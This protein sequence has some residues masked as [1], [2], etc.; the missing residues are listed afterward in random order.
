MFYIY[1]L[2]CLFFK[3]FFALLLELASFNLIMYVYSDNKGILFYLYSNQK[4]IFPTTGLSIW[5][6]LVSVAQL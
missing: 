6:V 2:Y 5:I 3:L 4:D 1:I